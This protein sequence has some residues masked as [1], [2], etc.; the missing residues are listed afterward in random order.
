MRDTKVPLSKCL[1][2]FS[3]EEAL[4]DLKCSNC[5]QVGCMKKVFSL[6]RLPPILIIQL[7]RFQFDRIS[8]RKLN[9]R[10]DFPFENLDLQN[11][12]ATAKSHSQVDEQLLE[13]KYRLYSVVHHLGALGGGHYVTTVKVRT[14]KSSSHIPQKGESKWYCFNDNVVTEIPDEDDV[15]APS[16]YLLFYIRNDVDKM[17]LSQFLKE[18]NLERERQ[19]ANF[20]TERDERPSMKTVNSSSSFDL[21]S[22]HRE[23]TVRSPPVDNS[24]NSEYRKTVREDVD[25][26]QTKTRRVKANNLGVKV[27][28]GQVSHRATNGLALDENGEDDSNCLIS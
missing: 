14:G 25:N 13:T 28:H 22:K 26:T 24:G 21:S 15:T 7:K 9:Q 27:P 3:E 8:R 11:Y 18:Y 23:T 12:L 19:E 4:E 2:K 17:E 16:A 10:V 20:Q 1:D 5:D 6:W